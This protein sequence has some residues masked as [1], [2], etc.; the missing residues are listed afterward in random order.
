MT[1]DKS[2]S[3]R[4]REPPRPKSYYGQYYL[5]RGDVPGLSYYPE[6]GIASE[7]GHA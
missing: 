4:R 3:Q 7:L 1:Q 5:L 6:Y 2:A